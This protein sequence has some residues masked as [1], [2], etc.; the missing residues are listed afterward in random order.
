MLSASDYGQDKDQYLSITNHLIEAPFREPLRFLQYIGEEGPG[1]TEN[2]PA[3][4]PLHRHI[5]LPYLRRPS[6]AHT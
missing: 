3:S 6:S 4:H 5:T 1:L 2:L